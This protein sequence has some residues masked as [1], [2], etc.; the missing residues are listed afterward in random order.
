M[1]ALSQRA[2]LLLQE[3]DHIVDIGTIVQFDAIFVAPPVWVTLP[4]SFYGNFLGVINS[5]ELFRF[6]TRA[7][8][9]TSNNADKQSLSLEK[10]IT[11]YL[12]GPLP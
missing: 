8:V 1:L 12:V 9:I 5:E 10:D 11:N 4:I 7:L 2:A 6:S 3:G